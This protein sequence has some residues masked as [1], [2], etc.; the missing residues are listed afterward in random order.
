MGLILWGWRWRRGYGFCPQL[1]HRHI[2]L[3]EWGGM[4][5]SFQ[6]WWSSNVRPPSAQKEK[7][8]SRVCITEAGGGTAGRSYFCQ[9]LLL[10]L[11]CGWIACFETQNLRSEVSF[12]R[13]SLCFFRVVKGHLSNLSAC[14]LLWEAILTSS[15]NSHRCGESVCVFLKNFSP[16]VYIQLPGPQWWVS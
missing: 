3:G 13:H 14:L 16:L 7:G 10:L 11:A 4:I 9:P 1:R 5:E 12:F 6:M 2:A 8:R 15:V